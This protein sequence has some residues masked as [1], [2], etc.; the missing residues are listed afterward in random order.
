MANNRVKS[1][2]A[3]LLFSMLCATAF[4]QTATVLRASNLLRS[5]SSGA[6]VI[7][8]L[9][10]GTQVTLT[11]TR[12][13]H[14]YYH[15][16]TADGTTGWVSAEDLNTSGGNPRNSSTGTQPATAS[17]SGD[18][19]SRLHAAQV[20]S[21]PQPLVIGG[22]QVCGATGDSNDPTAVALDTQKNRVDIP[23][24][25]AYIPV[26]WDDMVTTLKA[27]DVGN[28]QGAPVSVVGYLSHQV[29][30]ESEPPGESTNCHLLQ[31]NEVDWHIYL[32]KSPNQPIAKAVIV[33]TTPRTRPLHNW[34]KSALD[35]VVNRNVQVRMSGWLMFD[36]QHLDVVGTERA[37]VGEVHPITKIEIWDGNGWKDIQ[38]GN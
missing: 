36:S 14:G 16:Q 19:V 1:F 6:S 37:T 24:S 32:T 26:Q 11:S 2:L 31:D 25:S 18:L 29:K 21:V 28:V 27:G 7:A 33:E 34:D 12:T 38:T 4:A 17:A 3:L 9:P 10:A 13:R 35:A 30:V 20:P 5:S 15:V 8:S 23:D 22:Q